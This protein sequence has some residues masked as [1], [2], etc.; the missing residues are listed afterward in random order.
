[1][2]SQTEKDVYRLDSVTPSHINASIPFCLRQ[3][4]CT[5][6]EKTKELTSSSPEQVLK[7]SPGTAWIRGKFLLDLI[8]QCKTI[9]INLC[10]AVN[11]P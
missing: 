9:K 10:H 5:I 1:M 2:N 11:S 4:I 7:N 6:A 8:R 3:R